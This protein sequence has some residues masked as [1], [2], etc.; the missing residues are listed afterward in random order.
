VEQHEGEITLQSSPGAGA[1]FTIRLPLVG[2]A[3]AAEPTA[4]PQPAG[5]SQ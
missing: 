3:A 2:A 4:E 5:V 1:E